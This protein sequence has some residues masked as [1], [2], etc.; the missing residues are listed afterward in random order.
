MSLE[1]TKDGL[2]V[3]DFSSIYDRIL[4]QLKEAYQIDI[5]I[6]PNTPDGQRIGI[7]AKEVLDIESFMALLY[8][9]LD[10]DFATGAFQNVLLKWSGITKYA[11]RQSLSELTVVTDRALD[12]PSGYIVKDENGQEWETESSYSLISGSNTIT[13][14]A[15][16]YGEI[17]ALAGTI[18]EPVTIILGVQSVSNAEDATIGRDEE[19]E[20]EVRRRRNKS[21]E[22][23]A[24]STVGALV[25]KIAIIDGVYDV[26][27]YENDT[28]V[29]DA[30]KDMIDHSVWVV[31]KGGDSAE[32]AKDIAIQKTGGTPLKGDDFGFY[33]ET[34]DVYPD[35]PKIIT[36]KMNFDRPDDVR[37]YVKVNALRKVSDEPVDLELIKRNIAD[38]SFYI[39]DSLRASELY[40]NGYLAGTNF[41]LYDMEIS[42]DDITYTDQDIF[43][44]Y[45]GLFTL[46]TDD[47]T[48]TEVIP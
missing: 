12:V 48:V 43:S 44:G 32:I 33:V 9:Q 10:P 25:S 40:A 18:N 30:E 14:Y 22:N 2:S 34:V 11:S 45:D 15:T 36:H 27:V 6:D 24:F 21:L 19:T 47:I 5:D 4:T 8:A 7:S 23:P 31:V 42:I 29:Y 28:D 37:L 1:F 26:V 41:V 46:N 20:A 38:R 35:R 39:A 16:D 13:V 3:D 17:S